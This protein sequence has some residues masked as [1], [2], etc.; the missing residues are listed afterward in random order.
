MF[1]IIIVTIYVT[2]VVWNKY[3][4]IYY[5]FIDDINNISRPRLVL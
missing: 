1:K 3:Y 2:V 4:F 5:L